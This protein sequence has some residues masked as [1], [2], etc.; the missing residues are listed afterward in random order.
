MDKVEV[1]GIRRIFD[2]ARGMTDA[3]DFSLGQPDFDV[4]VPVRKAMADAVESGH[5][6]YTVTQGAPELRERLRRHLAEHAGFRDGAILVTAGS[7]GGLFQALAVLVEEGDEVIVPD[8]YFV[9]YG[10]LVNFFGAKPVILDTYPDFRV[11]P[12]TL[13]SLITPR[14]KVIIFN[15]PVNPT[16]VAYTREEVAAISAVAK[17]HGVLVI[18][19]EIYSAFSY[20]F[21]HESVLR[22]DGN[23]LLVGGFSKTYAATGWR[24]GF[25]A[26]PADIIDRMAMLQQFSFV[27]ANAPGQLAAA[28]ALDVDMSKHIADYRRKRDLVY[29]G[30]KDRFEIVRPQGAFYAFPKCPGGRDQDFVKK[31]VEQRVLVVPG[32]AASKRD[33]HFR[34]CY[35]APDRT[36]ERGIEILNKLARA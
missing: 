14:T 2:L 1:S 20:D 5:N 11:R 30:L 13:E 15:N 26:G 22:H 34:I 27:C 21:P 35:A 24:L 25:A 32:S 9:L 31:A 33:T 29:E 17:K 16:G 18:A 3:I 36:L 6:K 7:A 10:H 19:D 4:P 8:P 28:A 12:D 23:A